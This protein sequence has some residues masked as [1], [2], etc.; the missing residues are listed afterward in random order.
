MT[1]A[2]W[3][4]PT[5]ISVGKDVLKSLPDHCKRLNI[6]SPLLVTDPFLADMD[7]VIN[8][9]KNCEEKGLAIAVF[10]DVQGNPTDTNVNLGID[11]FNAG[12][13]DGIIAFGG[14]SSLDAAKAIAL[15]ANQSLTLW[16]FEDVGDN[17]A[18]ADESKIVPVIAIPTTAGTGSEVGRASVI[19]DSD[20][21][22]KKIIFHPKM[23][24]VQVLLDPMVTVGLP[25]HITAATGMDALSHSLEAYCAPG[26]H[27]MADG[28]AIESINL[29]KHFLYRAYLDGDDIDARTQLLVASSMGATAFQKGLGAMHALAHTLGGLYDKHHGLLNAILMPYVLEA[30]RSEI[31]D[32]MVVLA[33]ALSLQSP[34]F[35]AVNNWILSMRKTLAIPHTLAEIG[36][37]GDEVE[38]VGQLAVQDAAAG[39]NPILF[40]AEEYS[41]LFVHALTGQ[42]IQQ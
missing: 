35:D 32:K 3:N 4:Y 42:K 33:R 13:H 17:W 1:I 37:T 14:G 23:M 21:H 12:H 28:I 36:I 7:I 39:G 27:P 41:Q 5:A 31:E 11:A 6:Q 34:G 15:C 2:N 22:I 9:I 25:A 30:N 16:S 10:A 38:K 19:T 20:S 24:P 26:Y 40:T 8:A 29:V 18:Q